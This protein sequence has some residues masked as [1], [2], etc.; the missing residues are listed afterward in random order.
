MARSS[1][2]IA[3][4][5]LRLR[6]ACRCIILRCWRHSYGT[7]ASPTAMFRLLTPYSLRPRSPSSRHL[8]KLGA[9]YQLTHGS[10]SKFSLSSNPNGSMAR[11][12]EDLEDALL[13][14]RQ[15][16]R[17]NTI[18]SIAK[19]CMSASFDNF[20]HS[21]HI[22]FDHVHPHS[23]TSPTSVRH[24]QAGISLSSMSHIS[25]SPASY[26]SRAQ[27]VL[28]YVCPFYRRYPGPAGRLHQ[29]PRPRPSH[30][31]RPPES[32]PECSGK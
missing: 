10:S 8:V 26:Y 24:S 3:D 2:D 15:A 27:P 17:Q 16:R 13:R 5:L 20:I 4:T 32:S 19:V 7:F 9:A 1:E 31:C 14:L 11:S 25:S 22:A 18:R 28:Q 12:S 6:Q 21:S 30:F 29:L 23:V